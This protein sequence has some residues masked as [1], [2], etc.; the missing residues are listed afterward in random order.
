LTEFRAGSQRWIE[1]RRYDA[2]A[3]LD[4]EMR[5]PIELADWRSA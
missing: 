1:Y 3:R 5:L 4:T 2:D